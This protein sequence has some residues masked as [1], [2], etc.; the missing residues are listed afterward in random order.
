MVAEGLSLLLKKAIFIGLFNGISVGMRNL[1][2]S[3][4]Q[5][6]ND[7][8]IFC[9]SVMDQL[10]IIKRILRCFQLISGLKVN[11]SKSALFDIKVDT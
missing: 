1:Q 7:T 2:I 3:H 8:I 9:E 10:I 6:A 5:F 4:L 11:F